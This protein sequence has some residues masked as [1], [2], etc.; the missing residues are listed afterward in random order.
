MVIDFIDCV[1]YFFW[2]DHLVLFFLTLL[3]WIIIMGFLT[4]NH[5][6]TPKI[7]F[8]MMVFCTHGW[9][10]VNIFRFTRI[11]EEEGPVTLL[12]HILRLPSVSKLYWSHNMKLWGFHLQIS[13]PIC[14][15]PEFSVLWR[16]TLETVCTWFS[17]CQNESIEL[18]LLAK[19]R[20]R[21][22]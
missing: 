18:S 7:N 8:W 10:Q 13:G 16:N 4:L 15:K 19:W 3:I 2:G 6:C 11:H 5:T 20:L 9:I 1:L 12:P 17:F 14:M 21:Y 22:P